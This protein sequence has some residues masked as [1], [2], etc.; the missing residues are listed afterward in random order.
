MD[1]DVR[2][3]WDKASEPE[4]RELIEHVATM[5]GISDDEASLV[6]YQG[7]QWGWLH[8]AQFRAMRSPQDTAELKNIVRAW[9]SPRPMRTMV[10][11]AFFRSHFEAE[12]VAFVDENL[13]SKE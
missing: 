5:H 6:V 13:N 11:H 7:F 2:T 10:D 9:Y 3:A 12:F 4:W 8:W 1:R